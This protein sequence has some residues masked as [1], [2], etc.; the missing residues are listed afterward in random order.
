M[1]APLPA[2]ARIVVERPS[3]VPR[4]QEH[5]VRVEVAP[6]WR[7]SC[8]FGFRYYFFRGN[9]SRKKL[10]GISASSEKRENQASL[11]ERAQQA[12]PPVNQYTIIGSL[13]IANPVSSPPT[14]MYIRATYTEEF[15]HHELDEDNAKHHK[16]RWIFDR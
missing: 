4:R 5:N 12:P 11:E 1:C 9:R 15:V 6:L 14:G 16:T 7:E 13:L 2:C 8:R 10:S 3:I